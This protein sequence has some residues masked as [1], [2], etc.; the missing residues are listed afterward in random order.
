M[1]SSETTPTR[2]VTFMDAVLRGWRGRCPSCG[3]GR[4]FRA[5]LKVNDN[6]PACGEALHHHRADDFPAY[7]VIVIVG[8]IV[9]PLLLMVETDFAP[10]YWIHLMI[11]PALSLVLS[12]LL[13]PRVKGAVVALQWQLR[14]HGFD[15]RSKV[16]ARAP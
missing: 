16:P 7:I 4:L 8:H 2:D 13:L 15:Q 10:P 11:W 14:M 9:V 5:Y 1:T 12:L 6:C 3:E